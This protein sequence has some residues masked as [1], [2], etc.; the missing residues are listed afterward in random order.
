M[1]GANMID[2]RI[3]KPILIATLVCG[4]LDIVFAMVLTVLRG[5]EIPNMLR[6]VASGP[7]PQAI[8]WG[9]A[10]SALGLAVHFTLMAIMIAAFVFI[11]RSRTHLLDM[12]VRAGLAFGVLTY[13]IMNWVVVPLRFH[14]PLPPQL[15]P[16]ATQLFAHVVLVGFPTAFI[17]RRYLR[18]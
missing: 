18:G 5:R 14:T 1:N 4:T 12:P 17:T 10:G 16:I 2:G 15:L 7:F 11:A 3:G 8:E 13:F 9:A 6:Y